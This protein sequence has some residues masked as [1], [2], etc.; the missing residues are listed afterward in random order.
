MTKYKRNLSAIA[1]IFI[2]LSLPRF[3]LFC[4][5]EPILIDLEISSRYAYS[6]IFLHFNV[7]G[8]TDLAH[9]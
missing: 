2:F 8:Y 6:I 3:P 7:I 9:Q 1:N 5:C 4:P